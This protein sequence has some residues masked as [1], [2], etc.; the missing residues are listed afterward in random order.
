AGS[1]YPLLLAGV[2]TR[3][4]M[5]LRVEVR[6]AAV[7]RMVLGRLEPFARHLHLGRLGTLVDLQVD[8]AADGRREVRNETVIV[9]SGQRV[10][11]MVVAAGTTDGQTEESN[12][13]RAGH[14]VQLVIAGRFEFCFG[15]L[16]WKCAGAEKAGGRQG[17]GIVRRQLIAGNLP[18]DE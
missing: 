14:V 4:E 15:Q 1:R 8:L 17:Q 11:L 12:R 2:A 5:G 18:T 6:E 16:S 13:C 3:Q 7:V 10:I 9:T